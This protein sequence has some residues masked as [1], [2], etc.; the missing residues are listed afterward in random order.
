MQAPLCAKDV[1]SS[2]QMSIALTGKV[3]LHRGGR[4]AQ[5]PG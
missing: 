3:W 5:E 2:N 4:V 1:R